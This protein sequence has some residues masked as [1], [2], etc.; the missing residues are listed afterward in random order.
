MNIRNPKP[1]TIKKM[2]KI[3]AY[4]KDRYSFREIGEMMGHS[5]T[6]VKVLH[7]F[8]KNNILNKEVQA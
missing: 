1:A 5:T 8:Y 7:L 4:K 2:K 6:Y 3:D